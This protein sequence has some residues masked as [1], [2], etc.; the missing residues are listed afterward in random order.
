VELEARAGL[1]R[2][3][4]RLRSLSVN[5]NLSFISSK[6]R[7][8]QTT[9]RGNGEH[10]LV[11]QAPVILNLGLTWTSSGGRNELSLMSTTVGDRLKELNQ[12]Q[13][14]S[15]G[16]GIPNL[17]A[18]GMTTLDM[19]ASVTPFHSTRLRFA[20]GNLLDHPVQEFVGPIEMRRWATGRTYSVAFTVGS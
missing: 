2:L 9:N 13:V 7:S 20:A 6:I 1:S 17:Y 11:G 12:T 4:S 16:D 18:R 10:P 19:T 14:N 3:A 15:A 8:S 5:T